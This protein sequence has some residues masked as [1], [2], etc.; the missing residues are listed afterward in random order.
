MADPHCDFAI[1]ADSWNLALRADGYSTNTLITY[2]RAVRLFA[3]WLAEHH[4]GVGPDKVTR[5]HVRGW[6]VHIRESASSGSARSWLPGLRSFYRWAMEEGEAE[7]NPAQSVKTPPANNVRTPIIGLDVIR[8][9]IDTC[10]GRSFLDRRDAA[11]IYV[12]ADGGLRLAEVAGL[13]VDDADPR[14]RM[15]FVTGKGS[16]RSGPRRR[17]VSLGVKATRALDRYL[18]ERRRHP[19]AELPQLWLGD[20]SRAALT[21]SGIKALLKRRARLVGVDLHPHMFRHTWASQFRSAGGSEGDLMVLGGWSNRAMLDRYGKVDAA[22]RA[23]QAYRQ[24]SLGDR[25]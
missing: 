24:R 13:G 15:L 22:E 10:G 25:L 16:N 17:A 20:R 6:L 18:R 8:G 21:D 3:A 7:S 1:L 19:Y 14:E 9:M 11:V 4:P 23:Q 5:D 12:F 2:Q